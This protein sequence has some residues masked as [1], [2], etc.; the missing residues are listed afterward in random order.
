MKTRDLIDMLALAAI[1]GASFLFLRVAA[2]A[3]GPLAVAAVRVS[4][5]A[6][7]LLPLLIWRGEAK[8]MWQHAPLLLGAALLSAVLPFL[9]LSQAARSLPAGLL[10]ILNA[11]TPMWGALIGVLW[12]GE[13]LSRTRAG[14]LALGFAGVAM[15]S[16]DRSQFKAAGADGAVWLAL[17]STLLYALSVHYSKRYLSGLSAL[18]NSGGTL[19]ISALLLAG[20][21]WWMGP[22]PLAGQGVT[23][24]AVPHSAWLALAALAL[25]CT[26]LAYLMFYRLIARIGPSRALTVTFL[27]P[28]FGMLWGA[29][30]LD[31]HVSATMLISASVVLLGTWLSNRQLGTPAAA[32]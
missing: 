31:E 17:G 4:G 16:A 3:V 2:P 26:G 9:G 7:L 21:A 27:I 24:G 1:W 13:R 28:V 19:L 10:S 18:S 29:L 25:L 8:A 20:P 32:S 11:T 5:A 14:G 12:L 6:A 22:L 23:W 15:L 30:F